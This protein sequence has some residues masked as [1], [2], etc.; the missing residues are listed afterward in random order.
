MTV[1]SIWYLG[2]TILLFA[3]FAVIAVRTYSKKNREK[4]EE[5]KYRMLDDEQE[6]KHGR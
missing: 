1:A 3:I 4:G 2:V 5:P 6:G